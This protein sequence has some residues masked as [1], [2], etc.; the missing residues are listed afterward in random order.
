MGK[1]I[2]RLYTPRDGET[3]ARQAESPP[4]LRMRRP[5]LLQGHVTYLVPHNRAV[6]HMHLPII[7]YLQDESWYYIEQCY[8]TCNYKNDG[9]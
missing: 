2:H 6:H 9:V 4:P 3:S 5:L 7:L 8:R 1:L